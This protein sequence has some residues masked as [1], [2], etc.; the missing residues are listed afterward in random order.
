MILMFK[1]VY[2]QQT[3]R[4][5]LFV[6]D[7]SYVNKSGHLLS[8][9]VIYNFL[10]SQKFF[11][12]FF[13]ILMVICEIKWSY[14]FFFFFW[15]GHLQ[16]FKVAEIFK[17]FFFILMVICEIKWSLMIFIYLFATIKT[18]IWPETH[19][20]SKKYICDHYISC[21]TFKETKLQWPLYFTNDHKNKEK[22]WK[23]FATLKSCKWP[24]QKKKKNHMTT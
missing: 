23:N 14:D 18:H 17:I 20:L 19:I 10:W 22:I 21:M 6:Y 24:L 5:L 13:L 12:F 8:F 15:S 2:A 16:L 3:M 7:R 11:R 9:M 1:Y 4:P